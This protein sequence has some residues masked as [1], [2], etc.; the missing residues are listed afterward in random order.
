[1]LPNTASREAHALGQPCDEAG[2][3]RGSGSSVVF[4]NRAGA[5][6]RHEEGV[7]QHRQSE[8]K[9]ALPC[10]ESSVNRRKSGAACR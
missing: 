9:E 4:A 6:V 1:V 2:V 3:N 10:D 7:A 8:G 5:A